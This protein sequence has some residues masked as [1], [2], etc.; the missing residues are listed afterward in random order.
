MSTGQA[1][2]EGRRAVAR[3]DYLSG[4]RLAAPRRRFV[5]RLAA[6]A[7]AAGMAGA[8]G[9][10]ATAPSPSQTPSAPASPEPTVSASEAATLPPATPSP[11]PSASPTP[12]IAKPLAYFR[13]WMPDDAAPKDARG[14]ALTVYKNGLGKQYS[15][16]GVAQAALQYYDRWL[17]DTDPVKT[18]ADKA[19]FQTQ[20]NWL[21]KTQ[22]PDGRWLFN[23]KWGHMAAPW[24]SA[25]TEGLAMSVLLRAYWMTGNP[26]CITAINQARSTFERGLG[27]AHGVVKLVVI[28]SKTYQVYQEYQPAYQAPNVLNGWIFSMV[29]LYETGIYL[30]DV[31]SMLAVTAPDRGWAALKALL[32]YYDTGSWSRYYVTAPGTLQHGVWSTNTYHSLV[33]GQLRYVASITHDPFFTTWADK[34]QGYGTTCKAKGKCPPPH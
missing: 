3:D 10:A 9:Q 6:I 19:A 22:L 16:T 4:D 20:V 11:S 27:N 14:V 23:F 12:S 21:L 1:R 2:Y 34:F 33:I 7:L 31:A 5:R 25:M 24:W 28:N 29:G 17:I 30:H 18:A 15:P 8:C 26:A 32:P 13:N